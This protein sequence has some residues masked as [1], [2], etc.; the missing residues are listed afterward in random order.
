MILDP[1]MLIFRGLSFE[2]LDDGRVHVDSWYREEPKR[3]T[4]TEAKQLE[5][6]LK[7]GRADQPS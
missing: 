7:L 5:E 4:T 2:R 6:W 3:L 1:K